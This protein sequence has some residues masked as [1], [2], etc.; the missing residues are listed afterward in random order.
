MA[1]FALAALTLGWPLS[2][3]NAGRLYLTIGFRSTMVLGAVIGLAR[4]APAA[5]ARRRQLAAPPGRCRA[6]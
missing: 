2:A 6:S 4:L 5:H 3:A 1:G